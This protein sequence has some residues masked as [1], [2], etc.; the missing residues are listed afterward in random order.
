[1]EIGKKIKELRRGK[2]MTQEKLADLLG[3]SYQAVSKWETG[4]S[5]PDLSLIVPIARLFGISTDEL[6]GIG[7]EEARRAEFDAVY[8]NYWKK[9]VA[10]TYAVARQAVSEFPGDFKYLEWLASMEYYAAFCDDVVKEGGPETFGSMIEKS[11]KHYVTII[12]ECTDSGIRND[13]LLGIIDSLRHVGRSDEAVKYALL[14]PEKPGYGRDE[15]LE[16]CTEGAE[17]LKIRQR[18]VYAKAKELLFALRKIWFSSA[19]KTD[20]VRAAVDISEN[21][22]KTLVPDGNYCDFYWNLYQLYIERAEI[23]MADD[24]RDGAVA[25]LA[26]AKDLA[27]KD[28]ENNTSGRRF[29]CTI[30]DRTDGCEYDELTA[31]DSIK[32]WVWCANGKKFDPLRKREDFMKLFS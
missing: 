32:Y 29:T 19:E 26:A 4:V 11:V 10:E 28:D 20:C 15:L 6:F 8:D 14:A 21:I 12:E 25:N 27:L 9:D 5:S 24:D 2:D 30:F 1:M 3:V 13:A 16:M 31:D 22:I 7:S 18:I 23:C 17:K